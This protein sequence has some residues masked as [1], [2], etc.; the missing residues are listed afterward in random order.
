VFV[1][2]LAAEGALV[3]DPSLLLFE[4]VRQEAQYL[5][6]DTHWKP[7][8]M[9]R[10]AKHLATFILE[11]VELSA[12]QSTTYIKTAE[13][14]TNTGDIAKMLKLPANQT[15]FPSEQI[16]RHVVQTP[17]QEP[18]QPVQASE[19]LFLGDSFSNI[20]SLAGMGWGD[21][22]GF[23]EHLSAE[24]AQ[25]IDKIVINAGGANATRQAL[26]QELN[27]GHDR[28]TG[29]R[30]LVYQFAARE[31]FSG[32]WKLLSL[33]SDKARQRSATS[34]GEGITVTATIKTKTEPPVPRTVPYSECIIALHLEN[35][36]T[37]NLPA[38]FVV[39]LWGMRG[40]Q[41]TDAATFKMG[42]EVKLRLRPWSEV[43]TEYGSYNR[44]EL[45]N[46]ETWLLDVYWGEL[47]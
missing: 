43:E 9:E 47:P 10:V 27:R 17:S 2:A 22:A 46:E 8:A 31:L 3:Y 30:V 39:F 45:E 12:N 38:E 35:T 7:E 20:Y 15:L 21:S 1:E 6:T 19:I 28:L 40:N 33:P 5:K 16:T 25:P 11:Q 4:V 41:W 32:D 23:V 44:K 29:K 13:D 26:V 14:I 18:W 37:S 42:Q 36:G 24:L 34:I